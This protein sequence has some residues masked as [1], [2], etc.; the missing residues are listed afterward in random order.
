[1]QGS[2]RRNSQVV[3]TVVSEQNLSNSLQFGLS[4]ENAFALA[5]QPISTVNLMKV[6][7]FHDIHHYSISGRSFRL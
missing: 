7:S 2:V 1:M 4:T 3:F 6:M 5:S